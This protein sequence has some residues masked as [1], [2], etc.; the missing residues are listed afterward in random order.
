MKTIYRK[1][2][3]LVISTE[4]EFIDTEEYGS[5][6]L[7]CKECFIIT[8]FNPS[9]N[10][11]YEGASAEEIE[12]LNQIKVPESIS[13]M[14]LK[15]QLLLKEI[16]IQEVI[17]EINL[18]PDYMFSQVD[19]KIAIIKFESAVS[20]DRYNSD[21]NLVATLMGLSQDDLDEMFING[22]NQV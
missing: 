22:N 20:F 8:K 12:L 10:I 6:S 19:K 5:T 1:S 9:E 3:N 17:E 15:I 14:A 11:F 2:D 16:E 18:T 21:L 7:S 4:E 13:R